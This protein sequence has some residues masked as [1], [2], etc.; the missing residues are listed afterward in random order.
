MEVKGID[1]EDMYRKKILL[2]LKVTP[3]CV[4]LSD[5]LSFIARY[6]KWSRINLSSNVTIRNSQTI[7]PRWQ[8]KGG[9]QELAGIWGSVFNLGK[10]LLSSGTLKKWFGH[11]FKSNNFWNR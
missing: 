3:H 5:G 6:E 7:G 9:T 4:T 1:I 8:R 11:L 2:R 10:I